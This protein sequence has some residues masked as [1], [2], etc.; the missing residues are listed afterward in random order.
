MTLAATT[1]VKVTPVQNRVNVALE[2][3]A[4]GAAGAEDRGDAAADRRSRPAASP[5]RRRSGW[6]TRPC[7]RWP[8]SARSIRCQ[9]SSSSVQTHDGGARHPQHGVRHHSARRGAGRRRGPRRMGRGQQLSVRKN[10][11]PVPIYLPN[12]N[13]GPD[14]VAQDQGEAA[15]YADRL[16][17]AR[18]GDQRAGP[19]RLR[20]RRNADPSGSRRATGAAALRAPRRFLRRRIAR[21]ASSRARREPAIGSLAVEGLTLAGPAEQNFTWEPNRPARLDFPVTVPDPTPART[22]KLRFTLQRDADGARDAVEID[23]P[24]CRIAPACASTI[25][26]TS[27]RAPARACRR[28][29]RAFAPDRCGA[30]VTVAA[31]PAVVRLVA[32]AQL[33]RRISLWLHGAAHLAAPR[34]PWR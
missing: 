26:S 15:G 9:A 3:P 21:A 22:R 12:V 7:C 11:T 13:V 1:W 20:H 27:R 34:R 33:S 4:E 23:L 5:A 19:I 25:S 8:R 32:R 2:A 6:W 29:L 17:A 16:Q 10:F 30:I 18:Q 24:F 31:D 14:G 28:S